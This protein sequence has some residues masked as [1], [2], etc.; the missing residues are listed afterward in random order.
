MSKKLFQLG[1]AALVAAFAM[2]GAL[3]QV[4]ARDAAGAGARTPTAAEAQAL[5]PAAN[6]SARPVGMLNGKS[7]LRAVK[8]A[9]GTM[10]Q[11]LDTSTTMYSV[12]R[13]NADGTVSMFCVTGEESAQELVK[14]KQGA[15]VA[16]KASKEHQHE[17]K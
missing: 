17:V 3:A 16:V 11:E 4:A 7:T 15:K 14:V 9:D 6:K 13:R 8:H 12:A 1:G 10:E 2:T 5:S